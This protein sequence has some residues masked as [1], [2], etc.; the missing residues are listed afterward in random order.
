MSVE[1]ISVSSHKELKAFVQFYYDLYRSCPSAVPFLFSDEMKTLDKTKN[2]AF[3]FCDAKYFLAY[4]DGR[5]CGRIAG[6]VNHRANDYWQSKAVRFGWFDFVDDPEVS[7]AL[8]QAVAK[9]GASQG[10]TLLVGPMGFEDMDREGL[11]VEGFDEISS[12]YVNYNY[13]YYQE[14]LERLGFVKDNDYVEYKVKVPEVT[15]QKFA[16]TAEM[17]EKRYGLQTRKFNRHD[18]VEGRRAYE[19]FD[20]LNITYKDLYGFSHLSSSQIKRL[21]EE[22]ITLADLNL[23]SCVVDTRHNDKLV[24][25]GVSF[26]SFSRALRRTRDGR[27]WPMGWWHMLKVLKWHKTSIVD[28]L[29]IGVLPEYRVKGANALIFNDLIG[30]YQK[31]NF[32]YAQT[33]PQMETNKG[34]LSQWQYL[35]AECNRRH[36]VYIK[37]L[38]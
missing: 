36:R 21:V 34:V 24:G 19:L 14:H 23:V 15:P 11:L 13:P 29:L 2:P 35:D 28:L 16:R 10:L 20:V 38:E 6:I 27:L 31:Y 37:R 22:Y 9:W 5:L 32:K 17:V 25:F 33:G 7:S 1:I 26:P 18:M 30:W 3:E 8:L 12:M 4:K